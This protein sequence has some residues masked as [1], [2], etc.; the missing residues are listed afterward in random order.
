M[1]DVRRSRDEVLAQQHV[2][3]RQQQRG[4]AAGPDEQVLVGDLRRLGAAWVDHDH[5]AAPLVQRTHP[6]R[7]VGHGH[8][9]PVGGH[10][11]GTD[12]EEE[13]GAV[14]VG[15]REQQLVAEHLPGQEL[16]R[17]LVHRRGAEP[18]AGAQAADEGGAVRGRAERMGVGVAEVDTDG[19]AAVLAGGRGE[20]VG[21]E[22]EGLVPLHLLPARVLA[23]ADP[24]HRSAQPVGVGV[25]VG[26]GDALGADVPPRERVLGVA[27][28]AGDLAV[29]EGDPQ[30]ADRLA[31]V[32]HPQPGAGEAGGDRGV[33]EQAH[34]GIVP[35][36]ARARG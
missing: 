26:Q 2:H 16:V 32:A 33:R 4:V 6:V 30:A 1:V 35:P 21:H 8:E 12:D 29:G 7:E 18:V 11:V 5:P 31:Q 23:R 14:D 24:A 36:R 25:H 28:D 17:D 34:D 15:H 13:V 22:V 9:G 20:P 3:Q 19:V 27:A 10:R